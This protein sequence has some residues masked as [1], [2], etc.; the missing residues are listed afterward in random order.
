MSGKTRQRSMATA[1]RIA[2]IAAIIMMAGCV[3]TPA[4]TVNVAGAVVDAEPP[5]FDLNRMAG[6]YRNPDP[7]YVPDLLRLFNA[8][9]SA[10]T[11]ET[12]SYV[13][14]F[15][16][17]AMRRYPGEVEQWRWSITEPSLLVPFAYA[18]ALAGHPDRALEF[19]RGRG[20]VGMTSDGAAAWI[21]KPIELMEIGGPYHLNA[22]WG[23]F[24]VSGDLMFVDQIVSYVSSAI[25]TQS[26]DADDILFTASLGEKDTAK[27]EERRKI[28]VDAIGAKYLRDPRRTVAL[29][30]TS[31]ALVG[32]GKYAKD[33]AVIGRHL[34]AAV[35]AKPD[36]ATMMAIRRQIFRHAY[37]AKIASKIQNGSGMTGFAS[38]TEQYTD[39]ILNQLV[40]KHGDD[41][42]SF[43]P[44]EQRFGK[45]V[46]ISLAVIQPAATEVE[47]NVTFHPPNGRPSRQKPLILSARE[48]ATLRRVPVNIQ[49]NMLPVRGVYRAEVEGRFQGGQVVQFDNWFLVY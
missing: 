12:R 30:T 9:P 4:P 28:L 25:A 40:D 17:Q 43:H 6:F 13:V 49:P 8:Q 32:I 19:L 2:L 33:H 41:P 47:V 16:S 15:L 26:I 45:P 36:D 22:L 24:F 7:K 38:H 23:A 37:P 5:P 46:F 1:T 18:E 21:L 31:V 29:V 27:V 11:T 44:N 14:G 34:A 35:A 42:G 48:Q 3:T 39:L 10:L 20:H